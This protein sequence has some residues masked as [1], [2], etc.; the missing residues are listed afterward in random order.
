MEIIA[1]VEEWDD[2]IKVVNEKKEKTGWIK[3]ENITYTTID[4]AFALLVK[5][6]LEEQDAE[7]KVNQLEDLLENNPYPNSIFITQLRNRMEEEKELLRESRDD[8]DRE[9]Q[10]RR[11]R[12]R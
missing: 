9:D 10:D 11:Q 1:V 4:L 2:W 6:N 5:R 7:Q 3:K 8:R 12:R